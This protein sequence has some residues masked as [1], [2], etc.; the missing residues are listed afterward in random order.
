M[1]VVCYPWTLR[2]SFQL[3]KVGPKVSHLLLNFLLRNAYASPS[4][5]FLVLEGPLPLNPNL[6]VTL[7][8]FNQAGREGA[9]NRKVFVV[10]VASAGLRLALYPCLCCMI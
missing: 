7:K 10:C 9:G 8:L 5:F 1:C 3:D 2:V 6:L 4:S